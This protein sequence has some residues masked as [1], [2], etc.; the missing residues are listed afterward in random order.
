MRLSAAA[1]ALVLAAPAARAEPV[2]ALRLALAPSFGSAAADV[3][4]SDV[5]TM[6]FPLQLDALWRHRNVSAGGYAS[7][8]RGRV[9]ACS[10]SCSAS[11]WRLGLQAT[12]SFAPVRGAEPWAGLAT[13]YEWAS[14]RRERAGAEVK[15]TWKGFE[16][17]AL[18]G[19]VEWRLGRRF[20]LGP[21]LLLGFGRYSDLSVETGFGSAEAPIAERAFHGWFHAGVR[22]RLVLGGER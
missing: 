1:L 22:G 21:F 13:G 16:V 11:V 15:S 19:G 17:L 7:W 3:P 4:V 8:G 9:D 20:A 6:Q 5:V 10:G 12:W 18:Q 2:A 14:A